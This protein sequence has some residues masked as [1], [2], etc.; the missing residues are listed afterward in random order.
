MFYEIEKI[1]TAPSGNRTQIPRMG[2]SDD[3]HYTNGAFFAI[4]QFGMYHVVRYF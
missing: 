2:I 3:N 4:L 1:D